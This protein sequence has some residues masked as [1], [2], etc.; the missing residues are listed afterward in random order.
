MGTRTF[1]G[2]SMI[3]LPVWLSGCSEESSRP[4][5]ADPPPETRI[6]HP[7]SR[8]PQVFVVSDSIVVYAGARD[9]GARRA[10]GSIESLV[11]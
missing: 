4:V 10:P 1:A 2:L 3:L 7:Y 6:L 11:L 5:E 8:E 9:L